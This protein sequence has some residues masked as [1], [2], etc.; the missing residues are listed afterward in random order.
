MDIHNENGITPKNKEYFTIE[1]LYLN[2]IVKVN[3]FMTELIDTFDVA[4]LWKSFPD[5]LLERNNKSQELNS[6]MFGS[7]YLALYQNSFLTFI[8]I[9][10]IRMIQKHFLYQNRYRHTKEIKN[11][12]KSW[13][14]R[15]L[16]VKT[17]KEEII[18]I[19]KLFISLFNL[20]EYDDL[21]QIVNILEDSDINNNKK[22]DK[23]LILNFI[24]QALIEIPIKLSVN[25]KVNSLSNYESSTNLTRVLDFANKQKVNLDFLPKNINNINSIDKNITILK[26]FYEYFNQNNKLKYINFDVIKRFMA[27]CESGIHIM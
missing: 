17:K 8:K 1:R 6:F 14:G 22:P 3:G 5:T 4:I 23:N 26:I 7:R 19:V 15:T 27:S 25:I 12:I 16:K 24:K 20:P 13:S 18:S 9:F 11:L 21:C 10:I 2:N